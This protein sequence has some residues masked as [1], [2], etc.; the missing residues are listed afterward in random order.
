MAEGL[1]GNVEPESLIGERIAGRFVVERL[2][3]TGEL[4]T[5]FRAYDDRLHRRVTVKLF[6]PRHRDDVHVVEAQLAAARAVARLSHEHVAMV[7][8][9]GEH[10]G[11]PLVVL[12][13]VRGENLQERIERFA[14]LASGE[15]VTY[16]LQIARA[17]AYAH[18][19]GVVHGN[20]RPGN[21]LLTEEHDV[22]LVDFG[23]GSY[24]A[25][26]V[27]DPFAAPE[28][29][30][31]DATAPAE[32]SDDV[33]ALGALVFVALTE[34]A[35]QAG[36]DP[37]ELQLLRPD[38]SP[39]LA[40]IVA[41]ALA[42]DPEDRFLSMREFAAELSGVRELTIAAVQPHEHGQ[43][44]R[45][46]S[47]QD[48]DEATSEDDG[49][50]VLATTA[51]PRARRA[52]RETRRPRTGREVRARILAWSMVVAPLV[53]LVIFGIMIAG[54]RGSDQVDSKRRGAKGPDR[55]IAVASVAAFDPEPGDGDEHSDTKD[56]VF[57]GDPA[58]TWG[59]DGYDTRDFNRLKPGVGLMLQLAQDADVRDV[60]IQTNLPGWTME[61]RVADT[62]SSELDGWKRVSKAVAVNDGM[63]VPVDLDGNETR[64]VLLWI[65]KLVIDTDDPNRA[66]A[67]IG[68]I[69]LTG[70]N[71]AS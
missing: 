22:K 48:M 28:L 13:H 54:E 3:G 29:R 37:G 57:D 66:R 46:F 1:P 47:T 27:G 39:R 5:A 42:T 12:E 19:H 59:T 26:L 18:G 40:G 9:R 14:P 11:R 51:V 71:G 7:I 15:V 23:G 25:Q 61:V 36:L 65:T 38:V 31:V 16:A 34:Q 30:E 41:R 49:T 55:P 53:A 17:L 68:E 70:G 43:D 4:S 10:E 63:K 52:P 33:Y 2:I 64:Y 32:P 50:A 44:T 60:Q 67:R 24:V 35:P 20:L 58:T 56:N 6:H 62:P 8:D 21:V 45:A 69:K